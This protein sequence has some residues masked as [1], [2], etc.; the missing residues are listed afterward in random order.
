MKYL[1]SYI[2]DSFVTLVL[3]L[4][5]LVLLI[6][7]TPFKVNTKKLITYLA[8]GMLIL[9]FVDYYEWNLSLVAEPTH[10]EILWRVIFSDI[11]YVARPML[12]IVPVGL[13]TRKRKLFYGMI[14]LQVVNFILYFIVNWFSPHIAFWYDEI[15][16]GFMR[17][18]LGYFPHF[19]SFIYLVYLIATIISIYGRSPKHSIIVYFVCAALVIATLMVTL[20]N[21]SLNVK[22]LDPTIAVVLVFFYAYLQIEAMHDYK[23]LQEK[24][25]TDARDALL[26]SQIQPH[27]LYNTLNT[28]YY[29]CKIQSPLAADTVNNFSNYLRGNMEM[30]KDPNKMIPFSDDISHAK[31]YSDIESLRFDNIKVEYDVKHNDFMIPAITV[32]PMVENAVKHGVRNTENGLIL[33]RSRETEFY[34]VV[35]IIDNGIGYMRER[36]EL[37]ETKHTGLGILNVKMRIERMTGG[38]FDIDMVKGMGTTVTIKI[39]KKNDFQLMGNHLK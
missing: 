5:L 27:F 3:L 18:P 30:G 2:F 37:T 31:A 32:Q 28:I 22:I 19:V 33:V 12:L 9:S 23:D 13:L 11:G 8:V 24:H 29:L 1:E 39:P 15:N 20:A 25:L 6:P 7:H 4:G 16:N 14:S 17:G 26:S 34:H 36:N 21:K 35:E 38:T 10:K